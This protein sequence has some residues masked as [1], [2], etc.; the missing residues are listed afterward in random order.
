MMVGQSMAQFLGACQSGSWPHP[1]D[2]VTKK[3][4]RRPPSTIVILLLFRSFTLAVDQAAHAE[5]VAVLE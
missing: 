2:R 3:A 4:A 5:R 1:L